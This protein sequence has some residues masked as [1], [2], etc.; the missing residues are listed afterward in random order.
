MIKS[1]Q[2][3]TKESLQVKLHQFLNKLK[4]GF[5]L[6][7]YKHIHDITLGIFKSHSVIGN[8]IAQE[9]GE[10]ISLKKTCERLYRNLRRK[11]LGDRLQQH[12]IKEQSRDLNSEAVIIVDDSD[13]VKPKAKKME[14]LKKVRDGSTGA[15]DQNGY[16]LVN[17]IACQ[18]QTE[19]YQIKPLCSDLVSRKIE[20]DS[21]IQLT[22]DR[23]VDIILASGNR[24][25]YV[26][27][28]GYDNR[29]MFTFMKEHGCNFII[30]AVGNRGLIV[31]GKEQGFYEVA[32]SIKRKLVVKSESELDTFQAG[33][34]RVKIRLDGS[35]RKDPCTIELWLVVARY[36]P[37]KK[38]GKAGFFYFFCDF[39]NQDYSTETIIQKAIQMYHLRW[40]I[41]EVH[42]HVKQEYG[43]EKIQLMHYC[44]LKNMNQLLLLAMCFVYSL[45]SYAY[46]LL[47]SFPHIMK[48]S[49][50]L[51]KQIYHFVYYRIAKVLSHCFAYVTRYHILK[52]GGKWVEDQQLI[53]PCLENGGM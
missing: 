23:L 7:E 9:L 2:I 46:Q 32:N 19:S 8:R 36:I 20:T 33:I 42:R 22:Q 30:R 21:L 3:R 10:E 47:Q 14:G 31:N 13:I 24:G 15:H 27:D 39:P 5:T 29:F 53:I 45:R 44:G 34:K 4:P 52:Y 16:D 6:P 25:T 26:F 41:E 11:D 28:R 48:Y 17:I 40:K 18:P 37:Q 1:H 12:I 38:G 51:W 35:P 43:W 50:R 49:N